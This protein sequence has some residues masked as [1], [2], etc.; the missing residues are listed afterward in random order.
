MPRYKIGQAVRTKMGLLKE[1]KDLPSNNLLGNEPLTTFGMQKVGNKWRVI[2]MDFKDGELQDMDIGDLE[3][4]ALATERIR[5][6][7][8]KVTIGVE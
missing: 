8:A 2:T 6:A 3:I 7:L 5:M 4:R 1:E